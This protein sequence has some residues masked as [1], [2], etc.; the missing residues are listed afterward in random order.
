LIASLENEKSTLPVSMDEDGCELQLLDE[1]TPGVALDDERFAAHPGD[2][3]QI[4]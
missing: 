3:R 1:A 2:T 4:R